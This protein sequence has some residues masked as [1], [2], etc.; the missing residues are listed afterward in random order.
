MTNVNAEI[1]NWIRVAKGGPGS[2]DTPGHAFNGNQWTD[3]GA[4]INELRL[5]S[6]LAGKTHDSGVTY[7]ETKRYG[8]RPDS[9]QNELEQKKDL[10]LVGP[11]HLLGFAPT[12]PTT[13]FEREGLG[14]LKPQSPLRSEK[15][16]LPDGTN[17]TSYYTG[18]QL[19]KAKSLADEIYSRC[20]GLRA[21]IRL[22]QL[23][24]SD[25]NGRGAPWRSATISFT[26]VD[27]ELIKVQRHAE[28]ISEGIE[29]ALSRPLNGAMITSYPGARQQP[30]GDIYNASNGRLIPDE[31]EKLQ[32][33]L[34][35]ANLAMHQTI[36]KAALSDKGLVSSTPEMGAKA[37]ADAQS[38]EKEIP[39]LQKTW[40][41]AEDKYNDIADKIGLQESDEGVHYAKHDATGED[42]D[43]FDDASSAVN[44]AQRNYLDAL[45]RVYAGYAVAAAAAN[46]A[47][48]A[49][50]ANEYQAKATKAGAEYKKRTMGFD[51]SDSYGT[52]Y[53]R[54]SSM[55]SDYP[56]KSDYTNAD[57]TVFP[58][59]ED[60]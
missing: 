34:L 52:S 12:S 55:R 21:S 47:G 41:D 27:Y 56:P 39:S 23:V 40:G 8:Q 24:Y 4:Q 43:N 33:T 28:S 26:N 44:E 46:K 5:V 15:I 48:D 51:T 17:I 49:E 7:D 36:L 11:P 53:S 29:K 13:L 30:I 37:L 18:K 22:S 2:G 50:K 9:A 10:A 14:N 32:S 25:T 42:Y 1:E 19:E 20:S 31:I 38:A 60:Y 6:N 58:S 57:E 45:G 59:L 54:N 3:A 16:S 35:G